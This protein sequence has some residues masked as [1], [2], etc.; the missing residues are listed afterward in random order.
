MLLFVL[1]MS[2]RNTST[3]APATKEEGMESA[4]DTG[5][6]TEPS[7]APETEPQPSSEPESNPSSDPSQEDTATELE[8]DAR[9]KSGRATLAPKIDKMQRFCA[10][11]CRN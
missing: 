5:I 4:A 1:I 11:F 7:S 10:M 3:L 8:P 6:E 9:K 2:C